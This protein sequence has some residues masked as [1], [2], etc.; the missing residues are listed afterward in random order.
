MAPWELVKKCHHRGAAVSLCI[1]LSGLTLETIADRLGVSKGYLSK[2]VKG[3]ASLRG[4]LDDRLQAIC[5]N[6]APTQY[7]A[8]KFGFR[9]VESHDQKIQELEQELSRLRKSA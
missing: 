9:L 8:W 2:I 5:G 7:S 3:R 4:N 1:Q 6:Y